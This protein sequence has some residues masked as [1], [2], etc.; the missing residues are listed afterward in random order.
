MTRWSY[1]RIQLSKSKCLTHCHGDPTTIHPTKCIQMRPCPMIDGQERLRVTM[2][3]PYLW[4]LVESPGSRLF[5][6]DLLHWWWRHGLRQRGE[7]ET[8]GSGLCPGR[9]GGYLAAFV[10]TFWKFLDDMMMV[11]SETHGN[12]IEKPCLHWCLLG[13]HYSPCIAPFGVF[14]MI[15]GYWDGWSIVRFATLPGHML[16]VLNRVFPSLCRTLFITIY[17][18]K[19]K[20]I[21]YTYIYGFAPFTILIYF[22]C[23][24]PRFAMV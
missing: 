15:Y 16:D 8:H 20:Y 1:S 4:L 22:G 13:H 21:K 18:Y 24:Q 19:Y 10:L 11:M 14:G 12:S 2:S 5:A 6:G 9:Y 17:K 3:H 7:C 23:V